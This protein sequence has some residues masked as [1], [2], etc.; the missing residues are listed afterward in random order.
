MP[1]KLK[2][3]KVRVRVSPE[4]LS[5]RKRAAPVSVV[6]YRFLL[7]P[8]DSDRPQLAWTCTTL[9]PVCAGQYRVS[10]GLGGSMRF[11][12]NRDIRALS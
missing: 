5:G 9:M 3:S 2:R 10:N 12:I 7:A 1:H 8:T 6:R 4:P 11:D